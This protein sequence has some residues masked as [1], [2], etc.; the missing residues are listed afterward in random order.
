M[1]KTIKE[2]HADKL[3]MEQV[4]ASVLESFCVKYSL[5]DI[6]ITAERHVL[7]FEDGRVLSS[8]FDV[9]IFVTL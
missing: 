3:A 4:I 9:K 5:D 6:D 7:L 8:R 2:M 1:D